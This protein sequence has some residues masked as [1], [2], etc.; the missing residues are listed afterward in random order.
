MEIGKTYIVKCYKP[1]LNILGQLLARPDGH[2]YGPMV[3]D[4]QLN[5]YILAHSANDPEQH[6]VFTKQYWGFVERK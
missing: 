4:N 1:P 3:V 5:G 6:W 2:A